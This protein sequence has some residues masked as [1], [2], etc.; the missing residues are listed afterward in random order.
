MSKIHTIR[1]NYDLCLNPCF[2]G[3][4]SMRGQDYDQRQRVGV[5]ILVFVEVTL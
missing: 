2:R 3:S 5:L 4:Y 1:K